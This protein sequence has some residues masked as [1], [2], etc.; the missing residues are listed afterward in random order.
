MNDKQQMLETVKK[1]FEDWEALFAGLSEADIVA[2]QLPADLSIKDA[3][4]HLM[5]WQQRTIA[6]L[7]A[8]LLNTKPQFPQWPDKFDPDSE[9]DVEEINAWIHETYAEQ[10]WSAIYRDWKAGYLR[11]MELG[12]AIPEKDLVA[13]DK[14]Q[15]IKGYSLLQIMQFSYEHHHIDHLEPLQAWMRERG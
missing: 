7:E 12:E 9:D 10:P 3:M 6:R 11:F 2:R 5:I 13:T 1:E 14:Y 15:W 4:A 8:G